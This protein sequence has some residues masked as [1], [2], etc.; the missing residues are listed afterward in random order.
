[1]H[2]ELFAKIHNVI[3]C[4]DSY[5]EEKVDG[6]GRKRLFYIH[7]IIATMWILAFGVATDVVNEYV[8]IWKSTLILWFKKFASVVCEIWKWV[9]EPVVANVL[10]HMQV[11]E[12][13]VFQA[14]LGLQIVRIGHEKIA[15]LDGKANTKTR[16]VQGVWYGGNCNVK[17]MDL[18]CIH[19]ASKIQ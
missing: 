11:N 6:L 16:M 15:L 7:K 18:A 19:M 4:H 12:I 1:M 5:F 3:V 9:C 10:H 17:F 8:C 2:K 13:V 14:C